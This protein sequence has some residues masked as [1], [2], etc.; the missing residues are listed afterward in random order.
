ME[1]ISS[2]FL[3]S[4]ETECF[5]ADILRGIDSGYRVATPIRAGLKLFVYN[6]IFMFNKFVFLV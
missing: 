4:C 2:E 6:L 3:G 5:W 1:R